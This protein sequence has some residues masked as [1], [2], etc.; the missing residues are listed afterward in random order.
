MKLL[1]DVS[2]SSIANLAQEAETSGWDGFWGG[3]LGSKG[4]EAET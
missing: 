4:M 3:A 2:L 1:T